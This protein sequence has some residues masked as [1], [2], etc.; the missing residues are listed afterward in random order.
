MEDLV[1][2]LENTLIRD[3]LL[4]NIVVAWQI[5]VLQHSITTT[6]A[7]GTPRM[8]YESSVTVVQPEQPLRSFP[9]CSCRA[10]HSLKVLPRLNFCSCAKHLTRCHLVSCSTPCGYSFPFTGNPQGPSSPELNGARCHWCTAV[11]ISTGPQG[12]ADKLQNIPQLQ[13]CKT[14][15]EGT[16]G[17]ATIT[18][19]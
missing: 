6:L 14:L 5:A 9:L 10:R 8:K 12:P 2:I 16:G 13:F 3:H 11:G 4:S 1:C 17:E 15:P 7:K 19:N 18:F